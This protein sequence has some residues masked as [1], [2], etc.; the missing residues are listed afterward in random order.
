MRVGTKSLLFGVHAFW[1][2][3]FLVA[4]AW[5]I[6]RRKRPDLFWHRLSDWRLWASF[7]FHDIGYLGKP[8]MDDEEGE[9]HPRLGAMILG[10]LAGPYWEGFC[11]YHSRSY[12]VLDQTVVSTLGVA[13]KLAFAITP[14]WAYILMA[15]P[16]GELAEY[17]ARSCR[18]GKYAY[19]EASL[20]SRRAWIERAQRYNKRWVAAYLLGLSDPI[21]EA[22]DRERRLARY[23][24]SDT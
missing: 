6:L 1:Q 10:H 19:A 21:K 2:H 13:D 16:T 14:W 12:A 24:V 20:G 7:F 5:A 17:M 8:H 15:H 18:E 23:R 4:R 11:L 22:A 9:T 3:P